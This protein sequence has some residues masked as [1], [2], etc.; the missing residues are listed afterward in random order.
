MWNNI[1]RFA[2]DRLT[3]ATNAADAYGNEVEYRT[4]Q[5]NNAKD[6]V[7]GS[8][9]DKIG[10]GVDKI[11]DGVNQ[12]NSN[13]G[14]MIGGPVQAF[15]KAGVNPLAAVT[16]NKQELDQAFNHYKKN[17]DQLN[18]LDLKSNMMMRYY[19]G[20]G[21]NGLQFPEG[22]GNQILSDINESKKRWADPETAKQGYTPDYITQGI[23]NGKTPV[24]Y[25]GS[26]DAIVPSKSRLPSDVGSRKD[27]SL[28]LGSY[29]AEPQQ[30]GS[31]I[32]NE[33]YNFGYAPKEKGGV[34]RHQGK[35]YGPA[36]TPQ[37]IGK[38]LVQKGYGKPYSYQLQVFPNG[39][40]RQNK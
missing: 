12:F 15:T 36:L 33:D 9:V 32:I 39:E 16:Q 13:V 7:I 14:D 27:I 3:D 20:I 10:D 24:Y 38:G 17:P 35:N 25:G 2:G 29:W 37:D 40:L 21:A 22:T 19:S 34:D 8:V 30:D 26:S 18:E 4:K 23:K 5:L 1:K 28:S 31:Y 11:G 6:T